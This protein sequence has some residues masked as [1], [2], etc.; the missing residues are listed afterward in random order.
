VCA[1]GLEQ[2]VKVLLLKNKTGSRGWLK[3]ITKKQTTCKE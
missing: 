1:A 3:K 2:E